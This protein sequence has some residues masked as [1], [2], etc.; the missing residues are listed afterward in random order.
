M[1]LGKLVLLEV[2]GRLGNVKIAKKHFSM[3]KLDVLYIVEKL[4]R[5][6]FLQVKEH[7]NWTPG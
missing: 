7:A 3:L 5:R 4:R 6:A 1:N 2:H